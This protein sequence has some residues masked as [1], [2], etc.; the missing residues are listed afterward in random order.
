MTFKDHVEGIVK[1]AIDKTIRQQ[2]YILETE[3][4]T[5]MCKEYDDF[6]IS[7]IRIALQKIGPELGLI[8]RHLTNELKRFYKLTIKGCP[9]IYFPK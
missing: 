9:I 1:E 8:R 5:K 7:T 6:T 4:C 2:G 3:F